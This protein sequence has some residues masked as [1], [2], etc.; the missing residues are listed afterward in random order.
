M[1]GVARPYRG[2]IAVALVAMVVYAAGAGMLAGLIQQIVDGLIDVQPDTVRTIAFQ[3]M[4]AYTLKPQVK[5]L[6][7]KYGPLVQKI[8][9]AFKALDAHGAQEAARGRVTA[10]L[11]L[12][13][14]ELKS[15]QRLTLAREPSWHLR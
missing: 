8:L 10:T 4:L 13:A 6:G 15:Q 1:L 7:P 5:V 11:G 9:A 3:I 14:I 12:I 2:R